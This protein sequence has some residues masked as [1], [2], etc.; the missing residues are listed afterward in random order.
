MNI[1]KKPSLTSTQG[2]PRPYH[3]AFGKVW[4]LLDKLYHNLWDLMERF[5]IRAIAFP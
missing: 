3:K 5:A 1:S 4:D 2:I